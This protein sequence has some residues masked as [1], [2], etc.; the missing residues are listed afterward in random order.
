MHNTTVY[1]NVRTYPT[2]FLDITSQKSYAFHHHASHW[3]RGITIDETT[4]LHPGSRE[5]ENP[6]TLP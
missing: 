5:V 4:R 2:L 6:G 1:L 3:T